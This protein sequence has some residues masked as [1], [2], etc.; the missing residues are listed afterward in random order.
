M[1]AA[2]KIGY[3]Q[4]GVSLG[5]A[6][7]ILNSLA[8]SAPLHHFA[9]IVD[10]NGGSGCRKLAFS[11]DGVG[12]KI[13]LLRDFGLDATSGWDCVAMNANDLLCTGARPLW[14][15]D[16]YAQGRLRPQVFNR[17]LGGMREALKV[18][19]ASLIGGE[20]AELPGIF[21]RPEGYELAG[22]LVGEVEPLCRHWAVRCTQPGDLLIGLPSCG[23]H[24]NGFSL[25]RKVLKPKE[26][27]RY[28]KELLAPTR[29][30]HPDLKKIFSSKKLAHFVHAVA[31]ITGGGFFEKLP[32]ALGGDCAAVIEVGTWPVPPIF[33]LIQEKARLGFTEMMGVLNM[34]V[35]LVLVINPAGLKPLRQALPAPVFTIGKVAKKNQWPG[36]RGVVLV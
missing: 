2:G 24:A 21:V 8:A 32:R 7:Q 20:T 29:L 16:Y 17:V 25:I 4:S 15:L 34:G 28:A 10:F 5:R 14:F 11:A 23:P 22:F 35:G 19:G 13:E 26:I 1:P 9:S 12:T 36:L 3:G 18:I 33:E 27:K 31:H 6:Y 30:Y